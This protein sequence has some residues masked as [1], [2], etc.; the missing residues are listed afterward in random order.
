MLWCIGVVNKNAQ[1]V[2]LWITPRRSWLNAQVYYTLADCN[3]PTPL[4]RFV[5][6]LLYKL[7]LHCYAA[8]GKI[9]TD[10]SRCVVRL[11]QQSFL[12]YLQSQ[13]TQQIHHD[14]IKVTAAHTCCM[15]DGLTVA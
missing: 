13:F 3:A 10:A 6:D 2:G 9:L 15:L 8:V 11:Q 5:L 1:T 7:Y 14:K 4:L 12:L